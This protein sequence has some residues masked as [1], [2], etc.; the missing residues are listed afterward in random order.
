MGSETGFGRA[1][2]CGMGRQ[3]WGFGRAVGYGI[4]D[5]KRIWG[6]RWGLGRLQ[7]L[8]WGMGGLQGEQD[9]GSGL[10]KR[11]W[12]VGELQSLE[13]G[14]GYGVWDWEQKNIGV[15]SGKGV[16]DLGC[17]VGGLQG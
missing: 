3:M 11:I 1:A 2:G 10:G 17:K 4:W 14:A 8:G 15:Q 6:L 7:D 12:K 13:W 9:M 16:W 5:G